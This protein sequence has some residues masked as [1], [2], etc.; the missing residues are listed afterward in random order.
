MRLIHSDLP[1]EEDL[2][3]TQGSNHYLGR[4]TKVAIGVDP[5]PDPHADGQAMTQDPPTDES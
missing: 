2:R 1:T 5:G 3:H 4:L